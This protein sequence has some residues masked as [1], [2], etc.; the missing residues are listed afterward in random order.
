MANTRGVTLTELIIVIAI[1]GI[2]VVALGFSFQDWI[3]K[4]KVEAQTKQIY[5]DLMN[6][7]ARAMQFNR[8]YYVQSVGARSYSLIEDANDNSVNDDAA[9]AGFPKPNFEYDIT[10]GVVAMPITFDKRGNIT[11]TGTI[12]IASTFSPDYDCIFIEQT[13][14]NMGQLSGGNCVAK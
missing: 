12:S 7:R 6:A 11:N 13:R 4:Y 8:I 9:I 14:I 5:S 10:W 3:G 2:L 1:V